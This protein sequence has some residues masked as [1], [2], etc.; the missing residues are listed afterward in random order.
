MIIFYSGT[1]GINRKRI[2]I[3]KELRLMWTFDI[4]RRE[5]GLGAQRYFR[6]LKQRRKKLK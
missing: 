4:C 6:S 2:P 1:E 5:H 3:L